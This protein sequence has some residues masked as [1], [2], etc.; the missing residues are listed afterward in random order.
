MKD[1]SDIKSLCLSVSS[2]SSGDY[3]RHEEACEAVQESLSSSSLRRKL[4][5]DGQGSYSGSDSSSPPSPER[6]HA[7]QERPS[8]NQEEGVVGGVQAVS[9]VFSSPLSCGISAPTPS[10]VSWIYIYNASS[11]LFYC[12][13]F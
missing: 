13:L 12:Y 4:F 5:L 1:Y 6:S 8:P 9:S 3:Y 2:L 10:T 11:V 7:R